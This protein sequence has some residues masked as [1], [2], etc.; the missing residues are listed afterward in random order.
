MIS[1]IISNKTQYT[2]NAGLLE[3]RCEICRYLMNMGIYYEPDE[4]CITVGG[5]EAL[6]DTFA[7]ILNTDDKV[8]IPN[9]GYPAYASCTKIL[10]G[11]QYIIISKMIFP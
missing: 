1:S 10:A 2:S 6:M 3:L 4:V 7:A 11:G 8:L 9:P 5:S